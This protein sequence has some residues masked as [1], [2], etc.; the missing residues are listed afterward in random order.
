MKIATWNVNSLTVRLPQ[1]I[2]W[3]KAQEALG[4]DHVIDV[5]SQLT[6][7]QLAVVS[8]LSTTRV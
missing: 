4:P 7:D 3:L 8:P 6:Y 1:V 2:D 5:P